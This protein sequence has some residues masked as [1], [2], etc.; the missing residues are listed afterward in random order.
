MTKREAWTIARI[1]ER[2]P[3]SVL[4]LA[5]TVG[6]QPPASDPADAGQSNGRT[7]TRRRAAERASAG[8][9]GDRGAATPALASIAQSRPIY[10]ANCRGGALG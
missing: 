2:A 10:R 6:G 4:A 9:A 8:A 3:R 5:L 7:V 1:V